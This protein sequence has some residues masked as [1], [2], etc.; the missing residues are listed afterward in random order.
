MADQESIFPDPDIL[1]SEIREAE[2]NAPENRPIVLVVEDDPSTRMVM[3]H[4]LRHIVRTDA[5]G[6]AADALRMAEAVPYDGVLLDL[7]LPDGDGLDIVDE[8][9][10]RTPYWGIP[11]IAVTAHALPS[12]R[13]SFLEMGLDAYLAKPFKRGDLQTL[14]RHFL[15]ESD[16][17]IDKGRKLIHEQEAEERSPSDAAPESGARDAPAK[18]QQIDISSSFS[19]PDA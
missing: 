5:A 19:G 8:L 15:V 12:G 3:R 13:G 7:K 6:T 2:C 11:I 17:A 4:A 9:R 1:W 16:D 18:T 14:V 10:E